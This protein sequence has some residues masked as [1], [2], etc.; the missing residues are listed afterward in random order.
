[1]PG[2][3]TRSPHSWFAVLRRRYLGPGLGLAMLLLVGC[4]SS[5]KTYG[6]DGRELYILNCSG[7]ARSWSMCLE[8]AGELCGAR[9]YDVLERTGGHGGHMISGARGQ[10]AWTGSSHQ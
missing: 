4:A 6:P 8:R 2:A 10:S 1:M 5:A 9:G 7:W 3:V